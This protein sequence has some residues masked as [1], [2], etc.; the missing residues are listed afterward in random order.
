MLCASHLAEAAPTPTM[1]PPMLPSDPPGPVQYAPAAGILRRRVTLPEISHPLH[2][3]PVGDALPGNAHQHS[4]GDAASASSFGL[5]SAAAAA[6]A[7]SSGSAQLRCTAAVTPGVTA[8]APRQRSTFSAPPHRDPQAKG[9]ATGATSPNPCL[10]RLFRQ[11]KP[12][13]RPPLPNHVRHASFSSEAN[14]MLRQDGGAGASNPTHTARVQGGVSDESVEWVGCL[15]GLS[16]VLGEVFLPLDIDQHVPAVASVGALAGRN[17]S[18]SAGERNGGAAPGERNGSVA[19][20]ER[21]G[22]A[23]GAGVGSMGPSQ[24]YIP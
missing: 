20:G 6:A 16:T 12:A 23:A 2:Y 18:A 1:G 10:H 21:N 17:S 15:E 4:L 14:A 22:G 7:S 19:A 11:R 9:E 8:A 13:P 3:L 5:V 24:P